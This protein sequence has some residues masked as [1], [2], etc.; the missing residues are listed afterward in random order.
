MK[1]SIIREVLAKMLYYMRVLVSPIQAK[2]LV[3]Q[4][5]SRLVTPYLARLTH[6]K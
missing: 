1:L 4:H 3:I 6:S 5:F 2:A